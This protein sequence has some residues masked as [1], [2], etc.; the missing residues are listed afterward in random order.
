[1]LMRVVILTAG[2][3]RGFLLACILA[4]S[5]RKTV[6]M[7]LAITNG[8]L[9]IYAHVRT[10]K[11]LRKEEKAMKNKTNRNIGIMIVAF[12]LFVV[13][14][15]ILIVFLIR[16]HENFE[17]NIKV[18]ENGV[19]EA[20]F[21]VRDLALVPTESREYHINLVC[22]AS[23]GYHVFLDYNEKK[24]GGMKHFVEVTVKVDGKTVHVGSLAELIDDGKTVTFDSEL[25]AD[26]P[27]VIT[28]VYR[29]PDD[30]GNEAQ[31]TYADFDI[32][33]K[34]VKS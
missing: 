4:L 7:T 28:V 31:G 33:L 32:C 26:D 15:V 14:S 24:D 9:N 3:Q 16:A 34:I 8:G 17:K 29:M 1:M 27:V 13:L 6:M 2:L 23:G 18:K 21:A 30:V 10:R 22:E 20:V 25:Y 12:L 5:G 11:R 19:T